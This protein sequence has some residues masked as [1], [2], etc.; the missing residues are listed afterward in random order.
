MERHRALD[1]EV[2]ALKA[3]IKA[4]EDKRDALVESA[5][6]KIS[7]DEARIAIIERLHLRLMNTYLAYLRT[8]QRACVKAVENLWSKYA[9][10]ARKIEDERDEAASQLH[11]FLLELGY[12]PQSGTIKTVE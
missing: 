6:K 9:V 10:T 8:D 5:R 4:I 11:S 3:T 1:D 2:K 12:A 7:E